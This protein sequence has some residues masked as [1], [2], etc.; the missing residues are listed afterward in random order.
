MFATRPATAFSLLAQL[1][2]VVG[3]VLGLAAP[4]FAQDLSAADRSAADL[5]LIH[6]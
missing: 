6:I 5:S 1:G 4:A 3:L 2:L